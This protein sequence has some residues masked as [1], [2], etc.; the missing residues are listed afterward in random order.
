M[1]LGILAEILYRAAS[2]LGPHTLPSS[3]VLK[4]IQ[5]PKLHLGSTESE[6]PG[7]GK[8]GDEHVQP[9]SKGFPSTLQFQAQ[10]FS[11]LD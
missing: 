1:R 8:L 2:L 5:S 10:C 7:G 4:N 9:D 11:N 3:A 6:F